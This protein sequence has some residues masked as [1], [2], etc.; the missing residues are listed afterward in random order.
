MKRLLC[1]LAVF[2]VLAGG[3]MKEATT[4][5]AG[6]LDSVESTLNSVESELGEP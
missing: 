2:G 5:P 1:V 3:C 6:D 4:P